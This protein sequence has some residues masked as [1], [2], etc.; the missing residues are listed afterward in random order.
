MNKRNEGY[1]EHRG[2]RDDSGEELKLTLSGYRTRARQMKK[3]EG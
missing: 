1:D 2:R 3:E